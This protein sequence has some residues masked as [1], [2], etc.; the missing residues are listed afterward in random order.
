MRVYCKI[1]L[2]GKCG[3]LWTGYFWLS[4]VNVWTGVNQEIVFSEIFKI[5]LDKLA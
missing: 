5:F 3:K 4:I 1:C 2:K